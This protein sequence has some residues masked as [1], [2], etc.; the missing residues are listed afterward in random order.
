MGPD[1]GSVPRPDAE[2][3]AAG[4]APRDVDERLWQRFRGAQDAFFAAR[5]AASAAQDQE[6]AANAAAKEQLLA[7]AEAWSRSPTWTPPSAP[8]A[9]SRSAGTPQARCP[10][11]GSRSWRAASARS[12]RPSA[13]WRTS[14]GAGRTPRSPAAPTTW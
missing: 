13:A 9:T 14:S 6:F 1:L 7:E 4:P 12:S 5:D 10:A 3:K 11:T 2:W 8:S